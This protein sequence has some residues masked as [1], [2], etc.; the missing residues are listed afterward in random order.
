LLEPGFSSSPVASRKGLVDATTTRPGLVR[1]PDSLALEFDG[2]IPAG[3]GQGQ[4]SSQGGRPTN[5]PLYRTN[6][7]RRRRPAVVHPFDLDGVPIGGRHLGLALHCYLLRAYLYVA[8]KLSAVSAGS[9]GP[10]EEH[11]VTRSGH[12]VHVSWLRTVGC[13]QM[14]PPIRRCV[15]RQTR[16]QS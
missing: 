9:L 10:V 16:P 11:R 5:K 2:L 12:T 8:V 15:L 4:P 13:G 1:S 3:R 14:C 7:P 6:L